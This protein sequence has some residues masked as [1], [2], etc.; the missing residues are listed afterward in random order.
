M[1]TDNIGEINAIQEYH[2]SIFP[3]DIL[4]RV[5]LIRTK[6]EHYEI[7]MEKTIIK[8]P[9]QCEYITQG[10]LRMQDSLI[11][12]SINLLKAIKWKL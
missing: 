4:I 1:I 5:N 11:R 10:C 2:D 7:T 8:N 3:S 12:T 6:F 9:P